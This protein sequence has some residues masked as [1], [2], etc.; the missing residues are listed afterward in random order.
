MSED[1]ISKAKMSN[2]KLAIIIVSVTIIIVTI[3]SLLALF[4]PRKLTLVASELKDLTADSISSIDIEKAPSCGPAEGD[5]IIL[6]MNDKVFI[7]AFISLVNE[8]VLVPELS[9]I[10]GGTHIEITINNIDGEKTTLIISQGK[11]N[12]TYFKID[13]DWDLINNIKH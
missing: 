4:L 7:D 1:K 3:V 6:E 9:L 2:A 8:T 11:I 5:I 13:T 12:G 10:T